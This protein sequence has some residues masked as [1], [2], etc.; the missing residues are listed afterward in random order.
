[1]LSSCIRRQVKAEG[2]SG[3]E[4]RCEPRVFSEWAVIALALA[5]KCKGRSSGVDGGDGDWWERCSAAGART[6]V[7]WRPA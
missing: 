3:T 5:Q 7:R 1:M 4:G 6:R 2:I